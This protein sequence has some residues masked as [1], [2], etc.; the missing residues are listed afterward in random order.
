[1][2]QNVFGLVTRLVRPKTI[3]TAS[4]KPILF[5]RIESKK[6]PANMANDQEE[7][8]AS[9]WGK[10]D[11]KSKSQAPAA[12]CK[13][14]LRLCL[15]YL[16]SQRPAEDCVLFVQDLEAVVTAHKYASRS[17]P[18]TYYSGVKF[19]KGA[20]N[21]KLSCTQN[22]MSLLKK[23][24]NGNDL[25]RKYPRPAGVEIPSFRKVLTYANCECPTS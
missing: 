8:N 4:A 1:M 21:R 25:C 12:C 23:Q 22:C 15:M 7:S 19:R 6:W 11:R 14:S 5:T 24:V 18:A 13:V 17:R 20:S 10:E 9:Y 2:N 3:L 16:P